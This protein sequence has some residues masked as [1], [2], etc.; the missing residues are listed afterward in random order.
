MCGMSVNKL[1]RLGFEVSHGASPSISV[2]LAGCPGVC[3]C[4]V[5]LHTPSSHPCHGSLL[6]TGRI[7]RVLTPCSFYPA[8]SQLSFCSKPFPVFSPWWVGLEFQAPYFYLSGQR[9]KADTA[10]VPTPNR[11][12]LALPLSSTFQAGGTVSS[13]QPREKN[14][15][16]Q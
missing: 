15:S 11:L 5:S 1:F 4:H 14:T 8:Y 6:G 12:L 3:V 9:P 2:L 10:P 13:Y 16:Q 7:N